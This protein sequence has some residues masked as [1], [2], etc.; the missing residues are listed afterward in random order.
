M[1]EADAPL[2]V[3]P[4]ASWRFT[5]AWLAVGVTVFTAPAIT[6]LA[7][8]SATFD[9]PVYVV[10]GLSYLTLGDFTMKDDAPPLVAY[11]A[12]LSPWVHGL[13]IP[14]GQLGFDDGLY[15]EYPFATRLLYRSGL[16]ADEILFWSRLA[17][18]L[19]FGLLLLTTVLLWST[20]LFG[21]RA[22]VFALLLTALSPNLLAHGRLVAA[23]FPCAATMLF[24]SFQMWR[25]TAKPGAARA[26]AAGAALGLALVTKFTALLL[27]PC[28]AIV[29]IVAA[30]RRELAPREAL[31]TAALVAAPAAGLVALSYGIPP[32]PMRYFSGVSAIYRNIDPNF[33][34]YL[35]G[36]LHPPGVPHYYLAT[37]A[38]KASAPLLALGIGSLFFMRR[39]GAGLL[40][41]LCLL[42]PALLLLLAS[43][44]DG[45]SAGVR[46]LLPLF[47]VLAISGS[48]FLA[49]SVGARASAWLAAAAVLLLWHAT[50]S[51]SSWPHYIP[52]TV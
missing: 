42:L 52:V 15:R 26:L 34:W 23:D 6:S 1:R 29:L 48:R 20:A 47:P 11:L 28:F 2:P 25:T 22:G 45:F 32:D 27:L 39:R 19:P 44:Q 12:G 21:R 16:D 10:A 5:L 7:R 50:S 40:A 37:L 4:R 43:T 41:E 38:V 49:P 9:E 18:L 31:T 35:F 36:S 51:L 3:T 30:W 8:K 17:V 46:R 33:Q 24:A 14:G 13:R